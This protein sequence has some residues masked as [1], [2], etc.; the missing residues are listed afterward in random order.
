MT[1]DQ[2]ERKRKTS[3]SRHVD[4]LRDHPVFWIVFT[5]LYAVV[6]LRLFRILMG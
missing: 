5:V 3:H 4:R 2:R 6:F 1:M